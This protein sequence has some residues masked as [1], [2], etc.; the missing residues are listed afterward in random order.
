M[1]K[2]HVLD[3]SVYELIAAGEVIERPSSAI[4]ELMENS[5]DAGATKITV[6][7]KNGGRTYM[8]VTDNG[9]GMSAEDVPLAF[10]R[11]ATS[12]LASKEDLE[13]IMTL[14]FRGE[15]LAS[16]CAVAKVE[17]MTKQPDALMGYHYQIEAG[18]EIE[19][20][21]IGCPNG[22]TFIVKDLFFNTPARQKF[23]KR[24]VSEGNNISDMVQKL[25][26]SHPDV[27]FK[28]IRDN[29]I[30]FVTPGDGKLLSAIYVILG[31]Q[32]YASCIPVDY[33]YLNLRITGY[34]TKP[35]ASF[36]SRANQ[37]FF[38]NSRYIKSTTCQFAVEDGYKDKMM[39]SK[40]AGC[41]L[42][43]EIDP[44]YVDVNYHPAK[45]QVRFTD[46]AIVHRAMMFAIKNSLML[47]DSPAEIELEPVK[48]P[49]LTAN[50]VYAKPIENEALQ[51]LSLKS[52][53]QAQTEREEEPEKPE[54]LNRPVIPEKP[55]PQI[56]KVKAVLSYGSGDVNAESKLDEL[57]GYAPSASQTKS[58]K[59]AKKSIEAPEGSMSGFKYLNSQSVVKQDKDKEKDKTK[60]SKSKNKE[61]SEVPPIK[62]FGEAFKTYIIAE[63][64]NEIIFIDKH[65]AH[66]RYIYEQIKNQQED[67]E[68]QMLIEPIN[69]RVSSRIYEA[70]SENLDM[71]RKLGLEV[72]P[73]PCSF[74]SISAL[75]AIAGDIEPMDIVERIGLAVRS[76]DEETC[77]SVFDDIYHTIACK[78]AIKAQSDTDKIEL[79]KL[80]DLVTKEDLRYC[81]HGRPILIKLNKSQIEKLF[82]RIT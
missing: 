70:V 25:A 30:E 78:A 80:L 81:P 50:E 15:A 37:I 29:K 12:K 8:R 40:Y 60:S 9:C 44:E 74:L 76:K 57:P 6:E 4:K 5:L 23:M 33:S 52:E 65:A 56:N 2:I 45:L 17:V 34:I 82:K 62:V 41:V 32:F 77:K 53:E 59:K 26:L 14:G 67:L 39:V 46:E 19:S 71:C 3:K 47:Y 38:V 51:Q 79:Q 36:A 43:I 24:D 13:S 27:S 22:T 72:K 10:V 21:E 48:E 16:I 64:G 75:P 73:L 7:I 18:D 61:T 68:M 69:I 63:C 58:S 42:N 35:L 11:H 49:I 54:E 1:A 55:E 20:G 31:K 66:E 28:F